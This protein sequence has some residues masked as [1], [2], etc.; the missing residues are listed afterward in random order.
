MTTFQQLHRIQLVSRVPLPL[1]AIRN[2]LLTQVQLLQL[3]V[4][5]LCARHSMQQME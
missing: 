3:I 4:S 1:A 5:P 2:H